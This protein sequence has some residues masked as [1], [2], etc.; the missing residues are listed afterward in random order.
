MALSSPFLSAHR[1]LVYVGA[2]EPRK[3]VLFLVDAFE[4]AERR[5]SRDL[6]LLIIGGGQGS[7]RLALERRIARSVFRDRIRIVDGHQ[8]REKRPFT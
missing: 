3:D 6:G 4:N 8:Q 7:Y 1:L 2:L 5:L